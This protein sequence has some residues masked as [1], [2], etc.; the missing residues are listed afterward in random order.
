M[1]SGEFKILF[2]KKLFTWSHRTKTYRFETLNELENLVIWQY[3][4][5]CFNVDT[6]SSG[7]L[8]ETKYLYQLHTIHASTINITKVPNKDTCVQ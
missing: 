4:V 5:V 3:F 6:E 7:I 2:P 1:I 8:I